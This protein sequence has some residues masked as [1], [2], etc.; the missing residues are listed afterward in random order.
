M[1]RSDA[2]DDSQD[3]RSQRGRGGR[4]RDVKPED[5]DSGSALD[6]SST[7]EDDSDGARIRKRELRDAH[8]KKQTRKRYRKLQ[9]RADGTSYSRRRSVARGRPS[10]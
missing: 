9:E 3:E 4:G 5:S 2:S 8:A 10:Y 7:D 1:A 6:I